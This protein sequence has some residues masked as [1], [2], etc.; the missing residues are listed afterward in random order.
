MI[1]I[2]GYISRHI[3]NTIKTA[4][5]IEVSILV[6]RFKL[7]ID[8]SPSLTPIFIPPPISPIAK[9]IAPTMITTTEMLILISF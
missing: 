5:I 7:G 1:G 9:K 2:W 3:P 4:P 8:A 6:V